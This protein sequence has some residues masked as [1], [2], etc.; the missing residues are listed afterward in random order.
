MVPDIFRPAI[1]H[2]RSLRAP[3][4]APPHWQRFDVTEIPHLIPWLYV[5]EG[6]GM[7]PGPYRFRIRLLGEAVKQ[8][9]GRDATGR[10]VDESLYG[11]R[12]GDYQNAF[13]LCLNQARPLLLSAALRRDDDLGRGAQRIPFRSV[14]MPFRAADPPWRILAVNQRLE[15][16]SLAGLGAV[17]SFDTPSEIRAIDIE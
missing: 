10:F 1:D 4:Q 11:D 3:E 16:S 2:W 7:P 13:A 8:V 12:A 5:L 17:L 6:N 9:T 15:G 14:L